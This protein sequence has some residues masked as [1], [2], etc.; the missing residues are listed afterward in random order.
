MHMDAGLVAGDSALVRGACSRRLV[1]VWLALMH[2]KL[3]GCLLQ[4]GGRIGCR[5]LGFVADFVL[6]DFCMA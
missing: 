6:P 4:T 3:F 2:G 5:R 1:N